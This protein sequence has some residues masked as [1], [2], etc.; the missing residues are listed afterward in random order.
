MLAAALPAEVDP[1][2][3]AVRLDQ[4]DPMNEAIVRQRDAIEGLLSQRVGSPVHLK[5]V[6]STR[7]GADSGPRP[8]R[9]SDAE[10]RAERLR[11]VQAKDATLGAAASELDLEIVD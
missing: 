5:L 11:L 6:I 1:P 10:S 2:V 3:L 8:R 4:D 9:L 7:L